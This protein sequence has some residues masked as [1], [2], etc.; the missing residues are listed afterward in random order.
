[1]SFT[2]MKALSN[3]DRKDMLPLMLPLWADSVKNIDS[4]EDYLIATSVVRLYCRLGLVDLAEDLASVVGVS[5][6]AESGPS[7]IP[8]FC[9]SNILAEISLGFITQG[10]VHKAQSCMDT[11]KALELYIEIDVAKKILKQFLINGRPHAIRRAITTLLALNDLDDHESV[12][13]VT[14][15]YIRSVEFVKGSVSMATLPPATCPEVCFIGRSN[16]GKSS[17]I[18]M[19]C[20]RKSLAFTSKSPGKTSEFNY[21][22]AKGVVGVQ[23]EDHLFH[24]VDLPGV[25]FARKDKALRERWANLLQQYATGRAELRA[26]YH[27]IDSRHGVLDADEECFSLLECLPMHAQYIVVLTKA[28]KHKDTDK[29]NKELQSV[30]NRVIEEVRKRTDREVK[31]L[32][33]S[34]NTRRGGVRVLSSLIDAV[35]ITNDQDVQVA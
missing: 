28:D 29:G 15:Y 32:L 16:V 24:L 22:E 10:S 33:T 30:M 14:N 1:M 26:V 21:F 9:Y 8:Q 34:S 17:L 25:G 23:K 18:N 2:V 19:I 7:T 3:L 27:L 5:T 35:A 11:M 20:N 13:M 6:A 4:D 31:I 12:Q